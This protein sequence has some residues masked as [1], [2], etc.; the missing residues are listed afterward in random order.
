MEEKPLKE[1]ISLLQ[2]F[3]GTWITMHVPSMVPPFTFWI[4]AEMYRRY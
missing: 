2:K 4:T 3:R 1:A